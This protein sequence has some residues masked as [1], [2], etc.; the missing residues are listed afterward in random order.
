[1][2]AHF[3]IYNSSK[4]FSPIFGTELIVR[5]YLYDR[6]ALGRKK[7]WEVIDQAKKWLKQKQKL[8]LI[9]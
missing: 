9:G 4:K 8:L 6:D 7:M 5:G 1:M 3:S 2:A